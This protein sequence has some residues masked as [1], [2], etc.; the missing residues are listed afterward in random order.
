MPGTFAPEGTVWA[1][2]GKGCGTG[3][4]SGSGRRVKTARLLTAA[5]V[6]AWEE[7][8]D[9]A[10]PGQ[11]E[12]SRSELADR[13]PLTVVEGRE[14]ETRA[15][16]NQVPADTATLAA[17]LTRLLLE[18]VSRGR[19]VPD[20]RPAAAFPCVGGPAMAGHGE[21]PGPGTGRPRPR[22]AQACPT[23]AGMAPSRSLPQAELAGEGTERP[24]CCELYCCTENV[25]VLVDD[26]AGASSAGTW[27]PAPGPPSPAGT[28]FTR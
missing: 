9:I 8:A 18:V 1:A 16:A 17:D 23:G 13:F 11:R 4:R 10:D 12:D 6:A 28:P 5:A 14:K 20:D 27:T 3:C 7:I 19:R 25:K 26:R 24:A 21:L 15:A 2:C 22:D